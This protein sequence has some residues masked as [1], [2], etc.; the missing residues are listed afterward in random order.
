VAE[1]TAALRATRRRRSRRCPRRGDGG[2]QVVGFADAEQMPRFVLGQ[3]LDHQP[4]MVARFCFSSA[5]PMP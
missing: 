2:E 5:P 3:L 1:Y 4:T